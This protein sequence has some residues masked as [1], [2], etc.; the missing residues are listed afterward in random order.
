[1]QLIVRTGDTLLPGKTVTAISFLPPLPQLAGQSRSFAPSNGDLAYL[2][3]FSDGSTAIY[4]V[5]FPGT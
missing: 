5:V 3:E 1:L 2:V 4:N